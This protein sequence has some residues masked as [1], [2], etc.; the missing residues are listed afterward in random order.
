MPVFPSGS[1]PLADALLVTSPASTSDCLMVQVPLIVLFVAPTAK[2]AIGF[3]VKAI[4]G[5]A[6][7]TETLVKGTF[8]VLVTAKV[9]VITSPTAPVPPTTAVL[10]KAKAGAGVCKEAAFT[11][12]NA[13]SDSPEKVTTSLFTC[14]AL[15]AVI[16]ILDNSNETSL[17][18]LVSFAAAKAPFI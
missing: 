15:T 11:A 3:P 18:S 1:V 10:T 13:Q 5:K 2:V 16:P 17:I 7:V 8:P 14:E 4:P 12:I 6:S 9:Y